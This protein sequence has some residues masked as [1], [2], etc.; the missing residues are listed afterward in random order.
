MKIVD[1]FQP[2]FIFVIKGIYLKPNTLKSIKEI[3]SNIIISCFNPDDPFSLEK[4]SS[5]NNI[6]E[7]IKY[8]DVY[9]IWNKLLLDKLKEKG[10]NEVYYLPFAA[11]PNIIYPVELSHE[12]KTMFKCDISFVGNGD[13]ER[14]RYICNIKSLMEGRG[15]S[16]NFRIYGDN[17]KKAKR[18]ELKPKVEEKDLLSAFSG[19]KIDINILRK[20]NKKSHNMRTFEIPASGGF[21]L[22]ERSE[23]AMGFFTEGVEAEYFSSPEEL[24]DKCK[25]YLTHVEKRKDLEKKGYEKIF[26]AGYTYENRVREILGLVK[27]L[28]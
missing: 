23:E 1:S 19:S 26:S 28:L 21:M 15:N 4:G 25:Y 12:E 6:R 7:A 5:N 9:F 13:E 24:L 14:K 17:W 22:H 27:K 3:N 11:D 18:I 10:S 2:E 16:F 20:Q 8:Y